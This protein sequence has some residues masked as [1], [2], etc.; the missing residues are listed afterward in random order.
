MIDHGNGVRLGGTNFQDRHDKAYKLK[1][2]YVTQRG[3]LCWQS[4]A[5]C[6]SRNKHIPLSASQYIFPCGNH[7]LYTYPETLKKR[8]EFGF[9]RQSLVEYCLLRRDSAL[10]DISYAEDGS[11]ILRR[12]HI[13]TFCYSFVERNTF[14]QFKGSH[15]V[16]DIILNHGVVK[17]SN[18]HFIHKIWVLQFQN[19]Y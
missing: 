7:L 8:R 4:T 10:S 19:I 11:I 17:F 14:Q 1:Y 6:M 12:K 16:N 2:L 5:T 3:L 13:S 18:F 9:L 15:V